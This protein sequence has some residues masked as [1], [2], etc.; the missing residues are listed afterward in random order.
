MTEIMTN[1]IVGSSIG[2]THI[3][4][5]TANQDSVASWIAADGFHFCV[6]ISDGHGSSAHPYSEFGSKFAVSVSIN[7]Y[8]EF[9][10]RDPSSLDPLDLFQEIISRWSAQCN[11][12]FTEQILS[13]DPLKVFSLKLYGATLCIVYVFGDSISIASLGDSTVYFR[14]HNGRYSKFLI[15]DDSPGEATFSLC[16]SNAISSLEIAY[17]PYSPGIIVCS[18]DGIIKSLKSS[19]DYALI[20]NYYLDLLKTGCTVKQFSTD[21]SSQLETFS[22]EGSGDDCTLAIVYIPVDRKIFN[23]VSTLSDVTH[24][25]LENS[26]PNQKLILKKKISALVFTLLPLIS[27]LLIT[28]LLTTVIFYKPI[29]NQVL[30]W[31]RSSLCS[32]VLNPIQLQSQASQV[33]RQ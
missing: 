19:E 20:V 15:H 26:S 16:Q 17:I 2:N 29:K 32:K 7:V 1:I 11:L 23:S 6:A 22:R 30:L 14:N 18:T 21:L 27:L 5:E 4:K 8:K 12:H 3:A 33:K 28:V 9:F 13:V 24:A 10:E 25:H 31:I